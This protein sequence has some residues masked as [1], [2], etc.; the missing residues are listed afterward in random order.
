[1]PVWTDTGKKIN[2]KDLEKVEELVDADLPDDYRA[3]LL[4]HNG[5]TAVPALFDVV[6]VEG[7]ETTTVVDRF[8]SVG[9]GAGTPWDLATNISFYWENERIP[10]WVVPI[11]ADIAGNLVC[12]S[13]SDDDYGQV[14]FWDH[15]TELEYELDE[16]QAPLAESF[17]AFLEMLYDEGA[18]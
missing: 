4:E 2:E 6:T 8:Y 12:L 11:A 16:N 3:F 10:E 15:E 14:F 17:S 1:M 7:D 13:V 9:A 18:E 5:G